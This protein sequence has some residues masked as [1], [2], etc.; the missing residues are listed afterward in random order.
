MY[1]IKTC[2]QSSRY[3]SFWSHL[4]LLEA[5]GISLLPVKTIIWYPRL[6]L[7]YV[8]P[9]SPCSKGIYFLWLRSF[10]CQ[11]DVW[12]GMKGRYY[13]PFFWN[14]LLFGTQQWGTPIH[15]A[16]YSGTSLILLSFCIVIAYECHLVFCSAGLEQ[17]KLIKMNNILSG[18]GC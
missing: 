17:L 4:N 18:C 12:Y 7:Q 13:I 16:M 15:N 11:Q 8:Y 2:H 5:A 10:S 6:T 1:Y 9:V 14:Y 3:R